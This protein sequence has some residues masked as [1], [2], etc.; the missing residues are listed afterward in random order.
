MQR[1]NATGLQHPGKF[2]NGVLLFWNMMKR[3]KA[4][5]PIKTAVGKRQIWAFQRDELDLQLVAQGIR[6]NQ[7]LTDFQCFPR[8]IHGRDFAT[9][10]RKQSRHPAGAGTEIEDTNGRKQHQIRQDRGNSRAKLGRLMRRSEWL[11]CDGRIEIQGRKILVGTRRVFCERI[12]LH[13]ITEINERHECSTSK[14]IFSMFRE[15]G[16]SR[17]RYHQ[18]ESWGLKAIAKDLIGHIDPAVEQIATEHGPIHKLGC[19]AAVERPGV[20]GDI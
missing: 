14:M 16:T 7:S 13:Q 4:D 11:A 1:G 5:H 20:D 17:Q 19:I 6:A 15:S 10:Q 18:Q 3:I 2:R 8:Y 9:E 12:F